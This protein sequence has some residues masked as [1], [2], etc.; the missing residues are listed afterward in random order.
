[1][2]LELKCE[3][4]SPEVIVWAVFV[5]LETEVK[6]EEYNTHGLP[7]SSTPVARGPRHFARSKDRI[8]TGG[9]GF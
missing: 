6:C 1:M 7:A 5:D 4:F 8:G 3:F 2:G 9:V